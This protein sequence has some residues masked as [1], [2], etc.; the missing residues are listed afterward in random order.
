[1]VFIETEILENDSDEDKV[2]YLFECNEKFFRVI[3]SRQPL[4]KFEDGRNSVE[5][6]YRKRLDE[7]DSWDGGPDNKPSDL[8]EQRNIVYRELESLVRNLLQ[9]IFSE[10]APAISAKYR[11]PP[12]D[13]HTYMTRATFSFQLVTLNSQANSSLVTTW[14]LPISI[15]L[16]QIG[17]LL[18]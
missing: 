6:R 18:A 1:M 2:N 15:F 17:H 8:E 4:P 12:K 10:C 3:L 13:L 16:S 7:C 14:S 9:S 11:S 5:R